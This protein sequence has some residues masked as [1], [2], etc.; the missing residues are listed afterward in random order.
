[1]VTTS[2]P[3]CSPF[4]KGEHEGL[5][6]VT[7]LQGTRLLVESD[8]PFPINIDGEVST[9][10]RAAIDLFPASLKVIIPAL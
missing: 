10:T 5:D 6:V 7:I 2:R 9:E 1:M 8:Q 4:R 3:S